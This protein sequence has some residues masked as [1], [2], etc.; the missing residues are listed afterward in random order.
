[1]APYADLVWMETPTA[2]VED[3]R[4]FKERVRSFNKDIMLAYNLSPSFNWSQ[5]DEEYIKKFS[6]EIGDLG[7]V[8]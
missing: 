8:Y 7:Y 6:F 1:M 3:A 2:L 5:Y 4:D